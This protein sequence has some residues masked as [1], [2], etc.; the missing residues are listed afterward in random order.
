MGA[1][2][3]AS[4]GLALIPTGVLSFATFIF[5]AAQIS[6]PRTQLNISMQEALSTS[7]LAPGGRPETTPKHS[8]GSVIDCH[9]KWKCKPNEDT[10]FILKRTNRILIST[11][12][13]A[14]DLRTIHWLLDA[15]EKSSHPQAV[16]YSLALL[17]D[18]TKLHGIIPTEKTFTKLVR[19]IGAAGKGGEA[20]QT[21]IKDYMQGR[22]S[23]T[24][25]AFTYTAILEVYA[26]EA[27]QDA[28]AKAEELV[29]WMELQAEEGKKSIVK[30]NAHTYN[31]LI[32]A[33]GNI[34][35]PEK[36]EGCI[37]RMEAMYAKGLIDDMPNRY[38]Y[39]SAI[40]AWANSRKETSGIR[41]EAL[42]KM[43]DGNSR[44]KPDTISYNACIDAYAK[45]GDEEEAERLLRT[46]EESHDSAFNLLCKPNRKSYNSVIN[47]YAK[48]SKKNAPLDAE[49]IL[50]RMN[51]AGLRPDSF[52]FATLMNAWGRSMEFGK[53]ERVLQLYREM[54]QLYEEGITEL[55]PNVVVFNS[56]LNAC[57]Y[58]TGDLSEQQKAMS[59]A[60]HAFRE[61]DQSSFGKPDQI[62]YGTF[63]KVCQN[64][65]PPGN[66]RHHIVDVMFRK[67][68]KDG[69][70]GKLVLN[71][72][73]LA[74]SEEHFF[75]LVGNEPDTIDWLG[76][77]EKWRRNVI[78]EEGP[79]RQNALKR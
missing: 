40:N 56:I 45:N 18:G 69:Q 9:K 25:T 60:N 26:S 55:R 75:C 13:E 72:L 20:C 67:C 57:A 62:T 49:S 28:V 61:L 66:A 36:A 76:V 15:W 47:A 37:K 8:N 43:M 64:Q 32:R 46:M 17:L 50:R 53:A 4:M 11:P 63:F 27:T 71:Q 77:P 7:S 19:I 30:P 44:I 65:I 23:L 38:N 58:T 41:A 35:E 16:E 48:S 24:P 33:Y 74:A 14:V 70:V 10:K 42:L 54:L 34:H 29:G 3:S 68:V 73:K 6:S 59:I 12:K 79:R 2:T 78:D 39:N 52:T 1:I 31:A 22:F 5:P 21:F 51:D